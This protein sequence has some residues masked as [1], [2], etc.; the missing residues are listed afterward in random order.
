MRIRVPDGMVRAVWDRWES[1]SDFQMIPRRAFF[2]LTLET[3]LKWLS[4]NPIFPNMEECG[5]LHRDYLY[6]TQMFEAWQR[7]MFLEPD[8]DEPIDRLLWGDYERK[9]GVPEVL[10]GWAVIDS[11]NNQVREAYRRGRES[12]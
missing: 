7:K 11:H 12:K 1:Q 9:Q 5:K 8:P 2:E 6:F 3:A 10:N 4:E